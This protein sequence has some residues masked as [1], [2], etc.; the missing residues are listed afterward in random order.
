MKESRGME[1]NPSGNEAMMQKVERLDKIIAA[2]QG[3]AEDTHLDFFGRGSELYERYDTLADNKAR[4]GL[5]YEEVARIFGEIITEL[6]SKAVDG[7]LDESMLSDENLLKTYDML[8]SET[9]RGTVLDGVEREAGK[10]RE[11]LSEEYDKGSN[12]GGSIN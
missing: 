2:M 5:G 12:G 1:K 4:E 6:R 8:S 7:G 3:I 11:I 9:S 10:I